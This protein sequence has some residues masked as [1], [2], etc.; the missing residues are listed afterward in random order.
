[1]KTRIHCVPLS[2]ASRHVFSLWLLI[3]FFGPLLQ[4]QVIR[5]RVLNA[6]NGRPITNERINVSVGRWH[7]ADILAATNRDGVALLHLADNE[8]VAET[9]CSGWSARAF[10]PTGVDTISVAGDIY[11]ACQEY[12]KILPGDAATP[13]LLKEIMPS[14]PINKILESGVSAANT[15]G[16]FRARAT[17]GELI[18]YVRPRSFLEKLRM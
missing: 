3:A 2:Q 18:L 9:A 6:R 11:V 14:Y 15:C 16:K 13:H 7:G 10:R 12:G 1:M 17:P 4:A 5:I 8:F